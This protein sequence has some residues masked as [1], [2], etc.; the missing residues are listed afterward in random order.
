ML[1]IITS[2]I[3]LIAV[4]IG[5]AAGYPI[6]WVRRNRIGYNNPLQI[7][8]LCIVFSIISVLSATALASIERLF[9]TGVLSAGGVSTY[10]VYLI[11]PLFFLFV[12]R[13]TKRAEIFDTL[14][15]YV[16]PSLFL[17]RCSC[18]VAGCCLGAHIPGSTALW[19]TRELEL[20][21]YVIAFVLFLRKEK[22][23]NYVKGALFPLLMTAYGIFRFIEEFF[24]DADTTSIVHLAH[25]W[26]IL[27]IFAG[28]G[29]YIELKKQA[30]DGKKKG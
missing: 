19:P 5:I 23:D 28:A 17:Q 24:R 9:S 3:K 12:F 7:F 21:F 30:A 2:H 25:L 22:S 13:G 4:L 6:V 1:E 14:A 15:L 27:S 16:I 20:I 29:V 18:F 11:A 10:G 26:S 8:G